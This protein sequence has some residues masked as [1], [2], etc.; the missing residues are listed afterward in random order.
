MLINVPAD[1]YV[2][3]FGIS[4]SG[5]T[6]VACLQ[7]MD[8]VLQQFGQGL[9]PLG[10]GSNDVFVDFIAQ[11]K[12]YGYR[13]QENV[14]REEL[15]GFELK[16]N[17]SIHYRDKALLDQVVS[18]AARQ[19]IFDL[20]KV[21]YIVQNPVPV[22][23]RLLAE[24]A[25]VIQGKAAAYRQLFGISLA[26]SPLVVAHK[27]GVYYPSESYESYTAFEGE[28]VERSA[29]QSKYTIQDLR[30]SRTFYYNP[31]NANGFDVVINPG[32]GEPMVQ[33]TLYLK[34]R[35]ELDR[36]NRPASGK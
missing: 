2:A 29:Y 25:G 18:A 28:R 31:L 6:P 9:K 36:E 13:V 19:Q 24:A 1:E 26:A 7:K 14:A 12:I 15:T 27:P 35:Y 4:Q 8:T 16:K 32:K 17:V 23:G 10:I 33:Y 3:V 20:I 11:E 30:K 34:L 5:E 22:Q 21:D